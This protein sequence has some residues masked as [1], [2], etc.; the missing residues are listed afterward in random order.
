MAHPLLVSR[1]VRGL[2]RSSARHQ[3]AFTVS[4]LLRDETS[5][6]PRVA[7]PSFWK[8]L[9]PK[10]LR[11][12]NESQ[13]PIQKVKSRWRDPAVPFIVL[14]VV[15]GSFAINILSVKREML[16]FS[17]KTDAKLALLR[18]VLQRVKAGEEVDVA[19]LLGTGDPVHEKEWEE[20]M[21]ELETADVLAEAHK[22]KVAKAAERKAKREQR[23]EQ[24]PKASS[25]DVEVQPDVE[26][27]GRPTFVM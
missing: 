1:L 6:L 14:G 24:S 25:E 11:R 5:H 10:F 23:D 27:H 9:V 22:R 13:P 3:R 26:A 7:E 20:V 21:Q 8:G 12:N 18:E 19:K 15:V 17:R 4:R 16:N 2:A